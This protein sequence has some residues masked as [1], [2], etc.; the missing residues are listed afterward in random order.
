[1]SEQEFNDLRRQAEKELVKRQNQIKSLERADLE[2]LAHELA[3]HQVELEI[4]NDE[5]RRSRAEAEEARDRYLDLFDFAPVGYFTLDE[6]NRIIEANLTGCQ[7]LKIDR[8][9]LLKKSFTKFIN[10]QD[11][12]KFYLQRRKA[13][14]SGIN[15]TGEL[16]MQKADGTPFYAHIESLKAGEERLRLAVMDVTERRQAEELLARQTTQLEEAYK[17]MEAFSYSVS[18]DLKAPLRT[19]TAFSQIILE[20]YADKLDVKGKEQLINIREAG[21]LMARLIDDLLNLSHLGQA[22]LNLD[23]VN[24]SEVAKSI[25]DAL[26][27]NQPE[28]RVEFVIAPQLIVDGDRHLLQ[29]L[30]RNLLE[31]S[32]KFSGKCAQ[33][34][35]EVGQSI[36]EGRPAYFVKDNGAGFDVKYADRLFSPFRRLHT[37]EEF[38][39]DGIGLAL[40]QRIIRRHG[41]RIWA[42]SEV[43]RGATFYFTLGTLGTQLA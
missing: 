30:L 22:E 1:M 41:G 36:Q 2:S 34:R 7:L 37:K 18:H 21:Q 20:D 42:E 35:I 17:E 39:G 28:R 13:L 27:I 14:E 43:G 23:K 16:Q 4:Q 9:S 40:S 32:W 19:M 11:S 38:P 8:S 12:E 6:H 5:L 26:R 15:Q 33:T 25:A 31:N 3:V 29:I 24:L 10:T